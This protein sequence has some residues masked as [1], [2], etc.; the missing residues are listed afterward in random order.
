ML[1]AGTESIDRIGKSPSG[2]GDAIT[3]SSKNDVLVILTSQ[4][5][6]RCMIPPHAHWTVPTVAPIQPIAVPVHDT[7]SRDIMH[8]VRYGIVPTSRY[9][10]QK[11][12]MKSCTAQC[13]VQRVLKVVVTH[14]ES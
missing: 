1:S 9:D 11:F 14:E 3:S 4:I 5:M 10:S 7:L 2:L 8:I 13:A 6:Q 12:T